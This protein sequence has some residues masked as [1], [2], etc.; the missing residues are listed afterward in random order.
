MVKSILTVRTY[1]RQVYFLKIPICA[2]KNAYAYIYAHFVRTQRLYIRGLMYKRC[3]RM[4]L[5]VRTHSFR[6]VWV[7]ATPMVSWS[8]MSFCSLLD[9]DRESTENYTSTER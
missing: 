5:T 4:L 1:L 2:W 3:V 8:Q 6:R 9:R 7:L